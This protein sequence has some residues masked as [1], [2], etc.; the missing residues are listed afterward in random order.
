MRED[1]TGLRALAALAMLAVATAAQ[2][3]PGNGIRM[4]GTAAR[5][6]P[7]LELE[8]RYDSNIAFSDQGRQQA[9]WILHVRPGLSLVSQSELTEHIY[10]QGFDRDRPRRRGTRR[11]RPPDSRP[12]GDAWRLRS[13]RR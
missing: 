11:G 9:G 4:G 8:S 7:F 3:S 12:S 2:A 13:R 5:L 6:H 1:G 10:A